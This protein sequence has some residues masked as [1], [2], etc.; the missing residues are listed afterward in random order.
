M[1]R[2]PP[3]TIRYYKRYYEKEPYK[4]FAIGDVVRAPLKDGY[5]M[6]LPERIYCHT[7]IYIGNNSFISKYT[8]KFGGLIKQEKSDSLK[9]GC[10]W[11]QAVLLKRGHMMAAERAIQALAEYKASVVNN[12]TTYRHRVYKFWTANCHHFT[13][14]CW[15]IANA[16]AS[17]GFEDTNVMDAAIR[18]MTMRIGSEDV[19]R[20]LMNEMDERFDQ[21]LVINKQ[22]LVEATQIIEP[23]D[24]IETQLNVFEHV[25]VIYEKPATAATDT[26]YFGYKRPTPVPSEQDNWLHTLKNEDLYTGKHR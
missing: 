5:S 12:D 26:A 2:Q 19:E 3:Q 21:P 18:T 8:N 15:R 17:S 11:T 9:S 22:E 14:E 25:K 13:D 10:Y 23:V 1:D 24:P 16:D 20:L 6:F 7:G 4:G